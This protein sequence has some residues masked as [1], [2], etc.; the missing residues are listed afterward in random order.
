MH[1]KS[2]TTFYIRYTILYLTT[3]KSFT[4]RKVTK[5]FVSGLSSGPRRISV[6]GLCVW[7]KV[8]RTY[9]RSPCS[10]PREGKILVGSSLQQSTQSNCHSNYIIINFMSH[11]ENAPIMAYIPKD[12][13]IPKQ[14]GVIYE[15]ISKMVSTL[16]SQK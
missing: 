5:T 1:G 11:I 14:S 13:K 16:M 8:Q 2:A 3:I 15:Y 12:I 4:D 10:M 7:I 9:K 6:Q